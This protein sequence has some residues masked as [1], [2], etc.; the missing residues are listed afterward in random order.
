MPSILV[1]DDDE[2]ICETLKVIFERNSAFR[3]DVANT[4]ADAIKLS[5]MKTYNA[6]FIDIKLP[7]MSGVELLSKLR[8]TVP[9][10][11][12]VMITGYASLDNA[13]EALNQGADAYIRKPF[14]PDEL[15]VTLRGKLEAQMDELMMTQERISDFIKERVRAIESGTGEK[16]VM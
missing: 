5:K 3:V 9:R 11:I 15:L 12:K 2:S 14:R 1:I 10:M 16:Q 13:I 7:D 8:E 4:A 6:A